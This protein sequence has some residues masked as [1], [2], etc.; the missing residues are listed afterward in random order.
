MSDKF[1]VTTT[2]DT[3]DKDFPS[4]SKAEDAQDT[5][6][7][8]CEDCSDESDVQIESVDEVTDLDERTPD[9]VEV[10]DMTDE[11]DTETPEMPETPENM[12]TEPTPTET[13]KPDVSKSE[14]S[15]QLPDQQPGVDTDP[16]DWVPGDFIDHIDGTPAINRKGYDVLAHHYGISVETNI[17]V[18]PSENGF[19]YAEV[20]A[21]A[22]TEEGVTYTAHGSAHVDRGDDSFLLVEMADTRAAKRATARATGVGMVAVSELQNDL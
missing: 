5:H 20:E 9:G 7:A 18:S 12:E 14:A 22:T 13:N 19:E 1:K 15:Q 3:E 21:V 11:T 17:L 16:L 2:C 6:I 4:K 10:V 8:L